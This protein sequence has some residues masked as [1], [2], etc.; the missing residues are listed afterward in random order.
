MLK[1]K[2]CVFPLFAAV[3]PLAVGAFTPSPVQAQTMG[4]G[5]QMLCGNR[6]DIVSQLGEKYGER[7]RSLGVTGR[8]GV[9]EIFVSDET[10]SWTILLTN[11]QGTTCL[12]AAG[13]AYETVPTEIGGSPA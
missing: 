1:F 5:Q 11:A 4:G 13:E 9:L 2:T 7:R 12:M 6:T 10:G 8:R 3:A